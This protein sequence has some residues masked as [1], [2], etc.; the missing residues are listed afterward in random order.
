MHTAHHQELPQGGDDSYTEPAGGHTEPGKA[1][2]DGVAHNSAQR[3]QQAEDKGYGNEQ[4]EERSENG[5][6]QIGHELF[7]D[8]IDQAEQGHRQHNGQN[9]LGVIGHSGRDAKDCERLPVGGKNCEIGHHQNTAN[10]RTQ[11]TVDPQL[12]GCI[13]A[14]QDGH[15]VKSCVIQEI[16]QD[17][18]VAFHRVQAQQVGAKDGIN[19]TE[20]AAGQQHR[21]HGGHTARQI[22]HDIFEHLLERQL[23]PGN[24]GILSGGRIILDG[25]VG[26]DACQLAQ[27]LVHFGHIGANDDLILL[28]AADNPQHARDLLHVVIFGDAVVL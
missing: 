7:D 17:V 18:Q 6:Q 9:S 13:V 3:R 26:A 27:F 16:K 8:L 15:E 2:A 11:H 21:D 24:G 5:G 19:G 25:G 4:A 28:A 14:Y 1:A 20:Q 12:L 22:T 10:E 23:L